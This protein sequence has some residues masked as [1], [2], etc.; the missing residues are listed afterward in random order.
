MEWKIVSNY[1]IS[2]F[3]HHFEMNYGMRLMMILDAT[4]LQRDLMRHNQSNS[5]ANI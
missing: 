2:Y 3:V 5:K 4:P 1:S